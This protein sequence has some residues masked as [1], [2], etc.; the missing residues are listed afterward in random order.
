MCPA[1]SICGCIGA[2]CEH[3]CVCERWLIVLFVEKK[4]DTMTLGES[5]LL[6]SPFDFSMLVNVVYKHL[7]AINNMF[8]WECHKRHTENTI[9][10]E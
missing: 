6:D 2:V 9:Q 7:I 5:F 1:R 4:N 10:C 8:L 3:V